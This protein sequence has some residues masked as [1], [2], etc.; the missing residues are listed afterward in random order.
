MK[1]STTL[2]IDKQIGLLQELVISEMVEV[3]IPLTYLLTFIVA[4][5]GPNTELIGNVRNGYW[6]YTKTDD[7]GHTIEYVFMFFLVDVFSLIIS[8]TL[9]WCFCRINFYRAYSEIMKE[10]GIAFTIQMGS[11]L[12]GVSL[13]F[14]I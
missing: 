4:Y 12:N 10:F 3:V 6:Q 1:R 11:A 13:N 9:L 8:A 2:D 5:Y 14:S 7:V